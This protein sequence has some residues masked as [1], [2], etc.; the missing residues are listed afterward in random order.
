MWLPPEK[1]IVQ[2][3]GCAGFRLPSSAGSTKGTHAARKF[4]GLQAE[5]QAREYLR[6]ENE[7]TSEERTKME[8]H[9]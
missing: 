5:V 1:S 8:F 2:S 9:H 6:C 4:I 7:A 3:V